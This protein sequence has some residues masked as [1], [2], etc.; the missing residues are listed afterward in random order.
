MDVIAVTGTNGKSTTVRAV[1]AMI[2]AAGKVSGTTSTD[3]VRVG[4]EAL[5]HGDYA[6]PEG[7]RMVLRDHRVEIAV[8]DSATGAPLYEAET[9]LFDRPFVVPLDPAGR[10]SRSSRGGGGRR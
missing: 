5:D 1:G 2:R 9:Y 7:A 8:T 4:E 6:G 3:G 10:E